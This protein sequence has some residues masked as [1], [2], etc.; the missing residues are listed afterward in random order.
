VVLAWCAPTAPENSTGDY[1]REVIKSKISDD[2]VSDLRKIDPV[3]TPY[4]F[5][6]RNELAEGRGRIVPA[7]PWEFGS[8]PV[9]VREF[10]PT[11][12]DNSCSNPSFSKKKYA[13]PR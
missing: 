2:P 11:I 5:E 7:P 13:D 3:T 8:H 6:S 12:A 10:L 4:V 1:F 9:R